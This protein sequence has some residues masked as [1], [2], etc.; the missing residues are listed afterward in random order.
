MQQV[1]TIVAHEMT[2]DDKHYFELLHANLPSPM[3]AKTYTSRFIA[4]FQK[5]KFE[6][7]SLHHL[8]TNP[9]KY[10]KLMREVYANLN[11][12]KTTVNAILACYR[13]D[14]SLRTDY[15]DRYDRWSELHKDMQRLINMD[16]RKN[17]MSEN[18]KKNYIAWTE[19]KLKIVELEKQ[20]PFAQ[21]L[22]HAMRYLLLV[23]MTDLTPKRADFG[24]L[25]IYYDR[26]PGVKGQNYIVLNTRRNAGYLV[27]QQY[28]TA[29]TYLRHEEDFKP[30]TVRIIKQSLRRYPREHLFVDTRNEPYR[31]DASYAEF[32]RR[33]FGHFWDDRQLGVSLFRH[34]FLSEAVHWSDMTGQ[35]L[36]DLARDMQHSVSQQ[37]QYRFVAKD[38]ATRKCE[39]VCREK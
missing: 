9:D 17:K 3:S 39:C 15:G 19:I 25:R 32:V 23:V 38:N 12:L 2:K 27:L 4:L 28:K 21:G 35:E 5:P 30:E 1:N 29:K 22:R 10:W 16:I 37:Q 8:L 11:T 33:T 14:T 26:D 31:R 36:S 6:N 20:D 34:V 24:S 18:Q 7:V 13:Y